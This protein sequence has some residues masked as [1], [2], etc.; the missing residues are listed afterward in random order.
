MKRDVVDRQEM[1]ELLKLAHYIRERANLG[2]E[3]GRGTRKQ[4]LRTRLAAGACAL[5]VVLEEIEREA[6]DA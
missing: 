5:R 2:I 4:A 6:D 3:Q 1:K